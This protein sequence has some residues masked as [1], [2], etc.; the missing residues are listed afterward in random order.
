MAE[1]APRGA[2]AYAQVA[3]DVQGR[4]GGVRALYFSPLKNFLV[5]YELLGCVDIACGKIHTVWL[6]SGCTHLDYMKWGRGEGTCLPP[7]V[8]TLAPDVSHTGGGSLRMSGPQNESLFP[9]ACKIPISVLRG[10]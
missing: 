4:A 1:H 2:R 6:L 5:T 9:W 8:C 3:P 10:A 7:D